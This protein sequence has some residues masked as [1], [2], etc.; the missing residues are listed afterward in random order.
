F[1]LFSSSPCSLSYSYSQ[2]RTSRPWVRC[3]FPIR[4]LDRFAARRLEWPVHITV[5][6]LI[7]YSTGIAA[8][9]I[10]LHQAILQAVVAHDHEP[11]AGPDHLGTLRQQL[12]QRCELIVHSDPQR[13][14]NLGEEA[15]LLSAR[16]HRFQC[17]HQIL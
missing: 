1:P 11:S 4:G 12:K 14:E 7:L 9:Q 16:R 15:A 6:V 2:A 17:F 13:L 3:Y 8:A 10:V 5:D